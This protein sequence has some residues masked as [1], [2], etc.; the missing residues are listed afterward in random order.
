MCNPY[1]AAGI[2]AQVGGAVVQN[3]AAKRAN[4]ARAAA[5]SANTTRNTALE[6]ESRT[7]MND[8]TQQFAAQNM[9][10]GMV[11]ETDRLAGIYN[12]L[13]GR[14]AAPVMPSSGGAP[15]LIRDTNEAEMAK[16]VQFGIDQNKRLADL[17]SFG[18]YLANTISPQMN[19]SA[20]VAQITGNMMKGN[21]SVLQSE[22]E[23][24]NNKAYSPTAQLL[25]GA[26]QV[27]TGYGLYK[28]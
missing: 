3:Q 9:D 17:N 4:N 1:L 7:A 25:S 2:A 5:L 18:S 14:N 28:A 19:N 21:S 12:E 20:A 27:A 11:A 15:A 23:A 10:P 24:A 26:G 8:V 6:G 16:A 22:L 13:T